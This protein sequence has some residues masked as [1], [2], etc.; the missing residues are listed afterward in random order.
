MTMLVTGDGEPDMLIK[1][2]R[3]YQPFQIFGPV[4][5]FDEDASVA[6]SGILPFSI[7]EQHH[8]V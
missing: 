4:I 8:E 6:K 1:S 7:R 5:S 2:S 3:F